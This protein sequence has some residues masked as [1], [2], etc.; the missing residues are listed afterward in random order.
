MSDAT[1]RITEY[2][3]RA[4]SGD[5]HALNQVMEMA[6][7]EL[8]RIASRVMRGEN[9]GHTLQTTALINEAYVKLFGNAP[10][11]PQ[12]SHHF[13]ALAA[14]QMRRILVDHARGQ[15]AEIRGGGKVDQQLEDVCVVSPEPDRNVLALDDALNELEQ[16]DERAAKVVELK[17]FGGYTDQEVAEVLNINIA[18]VR[19]DWE[20]ARAWL[21]HYLEQV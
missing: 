7:R 8:H 2:L 1:P 12:D 18:R 5:Q 6:Y 11:K 20:F 9:A 10:V 14:R 19:R 15:N 4:N 21:L 13:Y 17:Y 16:V 3:D